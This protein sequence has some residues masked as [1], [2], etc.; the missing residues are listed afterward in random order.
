MASGLSGQNFAFTGYLP[1]KT[2]ERAARIR[3]F[4][5]SPENQARFSLT[6]YRNNQLVKSDSETCSPET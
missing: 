4:K 2:N 6:P 5:R 1:V 3:I